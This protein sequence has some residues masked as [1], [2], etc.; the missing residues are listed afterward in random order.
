MTAGVAGKSCQSTCQYGYL[1]HQHLMSRHSLSTA[2]N[3][4]RQQFGQLGRQH[5]TA[6]NAL[7]DHTSQCR[8]FQGSHSVISFASS[9]LHL[10][11]NRKICVRT[12]YQE[13]CKTRKRRGASPVTCNSSS[14][15]KWIARRAGDVPSTLGHQGFGRQAVA[16]STRDSSGVELARRL[17][18]LRAAATPDISAGPL[19]PST[20]RT[21]RKSK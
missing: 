1:T 20:K 15:H 4:Y 2:Q 12:V 8:T 6:G 19:A 13:S 10:A 17:R 5:L 9:A 7:A 3:K 11:M 16:R 14:N 21:P 18:S